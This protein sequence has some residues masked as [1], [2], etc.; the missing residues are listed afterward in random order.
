[1]R[2]PALRQIFKT[3]SSKLS[4]LVTPLGRVDKSSEYDGD[5][6]DFDEA[7]EV[8]EQFVVACCDTSELFELIE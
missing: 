6:S 2:R 5:C 1:M 3:P 7:H 8:D 4:G